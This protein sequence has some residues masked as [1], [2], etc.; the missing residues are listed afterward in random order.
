MSEK[1]R[2]ASQSWCRNTPGLPQRNRAFRT[3]AYSA[4]LL[5]VCY[6]IVLLGAQCTRAQQTLGGITGEVTD[7]AAAS[8]PDAT[9]TIVSDQTRLSRTQ[10]TNDTGS[11]D[12]VS[13]PIGSYTITFT[14]DGFQTQTV[15]SILVQGSRTVTVN[16]TLE[17]GQ[18][19]TTIIVAEN[20]LLNAVDTTNG[21]VLD[22]GQ[23]E[24]I[25]LPTGSFTG[26]AVL[27]PGVSAE[28]ASGTGTNSGLGNRPIWANGQ[29]DTSNSFLLNGVDSSNLFNGKSTSQV[30]SARVVNGTNGGLANNPGV[31][32]SN[33]SVYLAIGQALPTPAPESVQE[34]RVNT[35]MYGADQGSTSGAHIDLSTASGTNGFHGSGYL[36]RGTDWLNA[37]PLF[38]ELDPH[39]PASQKVPELHREVPGGTLGGPIIKDKLF[40]FVAYQHV[41]VSDQ[42]IGISRLTVPLGLTDTNRTAQGLAD[43]ANTNFAVPNG[44]PLLTAGNINTV[45][46]ALFQYKLPNGQFLIPSA[47]GPTPTAA[48]PDNAVIPGTAYFFSNQVVSNLDWN[49]TSKDTVSAKYYFQHDPST[50]PYAF[51]NVSGFNENTDAGSQVASLANTQ[52][53]KPNLSIVETFGFVREKVYITNQQPFTATDLGVDSFGSS[54]F[55]GISISDII[56]NSS[57]NNPGVFNENLNIG[58]GPT[59]QGAFTGVFQNRFNPSA[60]AIWTLGK[61][62]LS[63][64]GSYAFTQLNTRDERTGKG[65]VVSV[66]FYEFLQ[67]LVSPYANFLASAYLEG[68]ANRYYRANQAGPYIEDK[69]QIR[70]NLTMTLGLRWDWDG[71]LSEKFGRIFNF[72]PALYSFNQATGDVTSNG[73]IVAGNNNEGTPGVSDTTLTGRQW[74]FAPRFG[75]AWSPTRFHSKVVVRT[76]VGMYYDRGELFSYL[77]PA[78]AVGL[79]DSGPF[80]VNQAPPFVV[81]QS[82]T[83]FTAKYLG[84]FNTC[85]PNSPNGGSLSDPWGTIPP[86]VPSGNPADISKFLPN[87]SAIAAG[88]PLFSLGVYDRRNKLPY[89]INET[90]DIQW[91]PRSDLAVDI[92]YVGDLGRHQVIPVPFNQPGIA[93]PTDPIH[94]QEFTYGY[95]VLDAGGTPLPLPNGQG[96]YLATYEGGNTDLRVPYVGYSAESISYEASGSSAYNALQTHIEKRMSHGLQVGFSYT[97]S[98]SLDEQSALGL[99][100]NGNNP[101]D[102]RS[103]YAS[104]DFDR[105]HVFN[106]NY[107]Y[108]FPKAFNETSVR[109]RLADGWGLEGIAVLQSGQPY[110]VVDFSGAV[111]SIYYSVND[112]ITNPIA[113]LSPS[114]TPKEAYTGANGVN[115]PALNA[116]CFTVP[117]L[118]PGALDGAIPSSDPYETTFTTGERNIFRQAWQKRTDLSVVKVTKVSERISAR[119][120]LDVFNLTNTASLDVPENF[121]FQNSLFNGAPVAGTPPINA[122][123]AFYQPG[124]GLGIVHNTIGSA[125]QI[126]MS[127]QATF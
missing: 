39:I 15:P 5:T 66:D 103:G 71:G 97:Y 16:A 41:H 86:P 2:A 74:G 14:R 68:D 118:A 112:N 7:K 54:Y 117:L 40:A 17:V 3:I 111:G 61:H 84:F 25:P 124:S 91:Q 113:P 42:E 56:G 77:S 12:F 108:E 120:S 96:P 58:A 1:M 48:F 59:S 115:G 18:V 99:E 82:C 110:S 32:Q 11:Y 33:A 9:V 43:L 125:R 55:P 65:M 105:P 76:G 13:L 31:I 79:V 63:F 73:L 98:H 21:Y 70:P 64:G 46:L 19:T 36:H 44:Q 53:L 35:S 94:G 34:V 114:C 119:Y 45:A 72:D 23:I 102:L 92:G 100:Y 83:A 28:L 90:L 8:V 4:S 27:S 50:A 81:S 62:T 22:K 127:L 106:F 93:T 88:A 30:N 80:G 85:D 6:W 24:S 52:E 51:S 87:A 38:F 60:N 126:Q 101:L 109:G 116:G 122:P 29:R 37:A 69:Y 89:T 78:Y 57:P 121:I 47:N 95:Q 20:P 107:V 104:S 26:L 49:A 10:K 67:G 123:G 75:V